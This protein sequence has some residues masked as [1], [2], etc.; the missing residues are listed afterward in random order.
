M[1]LYATC[2]SWRSSAQGE[3]IDHGECKNTDNEQSLKKGAYSPASSTNT[4][5]VRIPLW[6]YDIH[7]CDL[8]SLSGL[9]LCGVFAVGV[10][11][12]LKELESISIIIV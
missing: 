12:R 2:S 7:V 8:S 3:S 10:S 1:H 11:M 9:S 5:S 4:G 6:L